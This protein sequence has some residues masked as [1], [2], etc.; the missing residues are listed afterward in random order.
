MFILE[1][2]YKIRHN[3]QPKPKF[4]LRKGWKLC[5]QNLKVSKWAAFPIKN[6][7]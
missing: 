3:L 4:K 7:K 5:F 1:P 2:K 6:W